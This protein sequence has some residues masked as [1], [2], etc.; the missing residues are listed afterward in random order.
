VVHRWS[1]HS[2]SFRLNVRVDRGIG[3]V[4][5]QI[6]GSAN[7]ICVA[8]IAAYV[9]CSTRTILGAGEVLFRKNC[10]EKW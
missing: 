10:H 4:H 2:Q 3:V 1:H 9:R 6:D 8:V 7:E 5:G